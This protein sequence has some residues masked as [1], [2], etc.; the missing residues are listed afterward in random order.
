MVNG[1][2]DLLSHWGLEGASINPIKVGLINE[3]WCVSSPANGRYTL[4]RLNKIFDPVVHEDIHAVT[5]HLAQR[6][7]LTPRLVPAA[8]GRLWV[9]E[10][11]QSWRVLTWVEGDVHSRADNPALIRE[12]GT[13]LGRFHRALSDLNHEFKSRRLGVHDTPKHLRKLTDALD[14]HR[15][16][17]QYDD[18]APIGHAI[19]EAAAALPRLPT[20]APRV[21]HGDPK[22]ANMVFFPDGRACCLIDL[23]TLARM[24]LPLE[25]GD[26][27]RSWC[28]PGGEDDVAARFDVPLFTAAIEGYADATRDWLTKDEQ[29]SLFL[30]ARTISVELASRFAADALLD[31]YFGWDET[32]FSSRSAHNLVRAKSQLQLAASMAEHAVEAE[33]ALDRA[34]TQNS[35][36]AVAR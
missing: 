31:C 6:G 35:L 29:Q 20:T 25:M 24:A 30:G 23:D 16:V 14:S 21:V 4:Q 32:R 15:H 13:L 19:L 34:W 7:L 5:E 18:V 11:D 36:G 12:A 28:N 1:P 8:D 17:P 22:L 2:T 33:A 26:A 3:T 9:T 10:D 27:L